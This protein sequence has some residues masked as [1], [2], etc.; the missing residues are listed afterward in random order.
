MQGNE[1]GDLHGL[2][3]EGLEH[4]KDMR[5]LLDH[6]EREL[7]NIDDDLETTVALA[8]V[9]ILTASQMTEAWIERVADETNMRELMAEMDEQMGPNEK[10]E[11]VT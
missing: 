7:T 10:P 8:A 11:D 3:V 2:A 9:M 4:I 5:R 6:A 1:N